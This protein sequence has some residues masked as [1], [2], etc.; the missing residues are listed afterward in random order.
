MKKALGA[1]LALAGAVGLAAAMASGTANATD[2]NFC[3][4]MHN[5][6]DGVSMRYDSGTTPLPVLLKGSCIYCHTGLN[7]TASLTTDPPRVIGTADPGYSGLAG[8]GANPGT[9]AGGDFWYVGN[10]PAGQASGHNVNLVD[11]ADTDLGT[12][13]GGTFVGQVE[14]A[15]TL[16]CHGDPA[17]LDPLLSMAGAHH[18]P[19][20]N[21]N[22]ALDGLTVGT[23]FRYLLG[24]LGREDSDWQHTESASD[25]N[26][27]AGVAR[28]ADNAVADTSTISGLCA[29][30]HGSFHNAGAGTD[31]FGINE[32]HAN[33]GS[34]TAT[35]VRHPT[36]YEMSAVAG[37]YQFFT[38][39]QPETPVGRLTGAVSMGVAGDDV[40]AGNRIVLCLSCHRAH[41][42]PYADAL[43]WSYGTMDVGTGVTNGCMNCHT[44]K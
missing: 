21:I 25:H 28:T 43:R 18:A 34:A 19:H 29:A 9:L 17:E 26:R 13:P 33:F 27:Y 8:S 36:D 42:S 44:A 3:H 11:A 6:Q 5:S 2:C 10:G 24:V 32:D 31:G 1:K 4:T 40:T 12:A 41:G 20:N 22:D 14:C 38:T 30:C 15:G 23:S 39:Y 35:W 7:S 16:G 37:E